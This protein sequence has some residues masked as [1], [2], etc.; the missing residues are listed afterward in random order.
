MIDKPTRNHWIIIIQDLIKSIRS[1]IVFIIAVVSVRGKYTIPCGII[2]VIGLVFMA[3]K[4]W[5]NTVYYAKDNILFYN[6]GVFEMS[7][8]EIPFDKISTIDIGQSLLDRIFG[9]CTVKIDSGSTAN[10]DSEFKIKTSY[11]IAEKLRDTILNVQD[12]NT[13]FEDIEEGKKEN[14]IKR[15]ITIKEIVKYAVTKGKLVWAMGAYFAVMN[16]AD[17]I[18]KFTETSIIKNLT[19]SIDINNLFLE[20]RIKLIAMILGMLIMV[21]VVVTIVSIIFEI[22]KMYNFT[23]K[24]QNKNFNISYGLLSK[25]EYSIP[26][27]K[28]HALKYKQSIMQQLLGIYTLE[29]IT[30]GYGDE[31]NEKAILYP[32][33]NDK[34]K[35]EFLSSILPEMIFSGEVRKPPKSSL[36]RFIFMRTL[37]FLVIL[38]GLYFIIYAIPVEIKV[39]V[40]V[41][42]TLF[43]MLLGYLNYKNTSLGVTEKSIIASS[44]SLT[45]TTTLIKQSSIQSIEKIQNPF[46]RKAKV[47]DYK[48]DIYANVLAEVVKVRHMDESLNSELD[49]NLIM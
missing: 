34:F 15:V 30:I 3:I 33:A 45:K 37:I 44:G 9:I 22:I 2:F 19:D 21:Y 25:K 35:E 17:D 23:V 12:E 48:I 26:I 7:K 49:K 8:Q 43:S 29:A 18:E 46:Q 28:I 39:G 14:T 40:I 32:I 6:T 31:K 41:V 4:R 24:V 5:Y 38:I 42:I 10:K 27:E 11:E 47:C 1:L 16:F 20:N 13:N 36:K